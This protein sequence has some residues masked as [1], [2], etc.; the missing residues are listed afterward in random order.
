M[1]YRAGAAGSTNASTVGMDRAR[2]TSNAQEEGD[3]AGTNLSNAR[4]ASFRPE[5]TDRESAEDQLPFMN[6]AST[7]TSFQQQPNQPAFS[8]GQ[9]GAS[10]QNF[11]SRRRQSSIPKTPMGPRPLDYVAGAGN[12]YVAVAPALA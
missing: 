11:T 3:D 5:V 6:L 1:P 2:V 8:Q 10:R 12:R 9:H 7:S 4:H